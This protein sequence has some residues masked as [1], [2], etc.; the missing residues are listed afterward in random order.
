LNNEKHGK[1]T[2]STK[3]V[4]ESSAQNTPKFICPICLPKPKVWD[5][6][7]KKL[8]WASVVRGQDNDKNCKVMK[9][10]AAVHSQKELAQN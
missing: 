5:F 8:H 2:H 3:M 7:E 6:N 1:W 10:P 9:L 4:V